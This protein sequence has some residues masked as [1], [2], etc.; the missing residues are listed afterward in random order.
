MAQVLEFLTGIETV[1]TAGTA[2]RFT[3]T[4]TL[5]RSIIITANS[6]NVSGEHIVVGDSNVVGAV[7]TRR[8]HPLA[9]GQSLTIDAATA[10]ERGLSG[11]EST[12]LINLADLYVDAVSSTELVSWIAFR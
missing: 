7:A 12:K 4:E 11:V 9:P 1:A 2:V 3:A 5:V 6:G 10:A 8:G